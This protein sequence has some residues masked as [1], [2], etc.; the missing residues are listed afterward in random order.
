[1]TDSPCMIFFIV[2]QSE[3]VCVCCVVASRVSPS[4]ETTVTDS[5]AAARACHRH[6]FYASA[7][8][9]RAGPRRAEAGGVRD[10]MGRL[11]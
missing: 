8:V 3:N 5:R 2:T 4:D 7:M 11:R 1:M 9:D 10:L 6:A